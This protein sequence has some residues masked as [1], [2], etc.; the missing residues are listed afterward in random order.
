MDRKEF[1]LKTGRWVSVGML[2][3]LLG[4]FIKRKAIKLDPDC[5]PKFCQECGKRDHCD[6]AVAKQ[7]LSNK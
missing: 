3:L 4:I 1:I 7:D 6:K 2:A 5:D